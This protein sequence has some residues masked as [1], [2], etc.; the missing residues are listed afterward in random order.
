MV[1]SLLLCVILAAGVV[2]SPSLLVAQTRDVDGHDAP[3]ERSGM[4]SE[5]ETNAAALILPADSSVFLQ[6]HEQA[7]V[8]R[9]TAMGEAVVASRSS[10][11]AFHRQQ[12]QQMAN[13]GILGGTELV[14]DETETPANPASSDG[15]GGAV[16]D[17]CDV[18]TYVLENKEMLQPYLCRG[19][20]TPG[21]QMAVRVI[22]FTLRARDAALVY[23]L[24]L[25]L[26]SVTVCMS[27]RAPS[28]SG[29]FGAG[30]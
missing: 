10:H 25:T 5:H 30:C 18:C 22:S 26:A 27:T 29:S 19:L 15:T 12:A 21:Q 14:G 7:V 4:Y 13:S 6:V 1:A 8:D 11:G 28:P 16:Q 2:A 3:T 24:T 23:C 9:A 20:K 17:E